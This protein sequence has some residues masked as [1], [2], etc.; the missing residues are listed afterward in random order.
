[1]KII[2]DYNKEK[3]TLCLL[4]KGRGSNNS[5]NPTKVYQLLVSRYGENPTEQVVSKFVDEYISE[6]NTS[7]D[8]YI[9]KYTIDWKSISAEY[10]KRA[11]SIF[12]VVLPQDITAY[13][14][15]NNRNP[16]SIVDNMFYVT[17]PKETVRKTIMHELWH[18]YTWY[19]LGTDQEEK[20]GKQKYNNVKEALTVLLNEECGDLMPDGIYDKG[21][22]QHQELREKIKRLWNEQKDIYW[23]WKEV[24][25]R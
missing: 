6:N 24:T 13:L 21:Y 14:T 1:M 7:P 15:I 10:H 16:Y 23:I 22:P 18:F 3:D 25:S 9:E 4:N 2:F 5:S 20:L 19:G 11:E 8:E 12:G 17:F